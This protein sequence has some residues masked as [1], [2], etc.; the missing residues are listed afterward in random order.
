VRAG[1]GADDLGVDAEVAEGLEELAA[2]A[3][4]GAVVDLRG[5]ARAL[6]EVARRQGVGDV[7]GFGDA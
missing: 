5:L 1:H 6:E 2:R 7:L 4:L 3:P